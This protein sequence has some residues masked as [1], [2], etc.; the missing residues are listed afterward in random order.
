MKA[1][2]IIQIH[3]PNGQVFKLARKDN[4][5]LSDTEIS[6]LRVKMGQCENVQLN[7][8]PPKIHGFK[9][10]VLILWGDVLKNSYITIDRYSVESNTELDK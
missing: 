2:D 9:S 6:E 7:V 5:P 8:F 3:L 1:E 10:K 4:T